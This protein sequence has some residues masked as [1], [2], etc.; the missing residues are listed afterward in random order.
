ML[1][2]F[3]PFCAAKN[4]FCFTSAQVQLRQLAV[5]ALNFKLLLQVNGHISTLV[6]AGLIY[7][8]RG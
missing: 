7:E 3:F 8:F 4:N 1:T 5:T 2:I 6:K